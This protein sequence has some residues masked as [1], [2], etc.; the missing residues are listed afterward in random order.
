MTLLRVSTMEENIEEC[1]DNDSWKTVYTAFKKKIVD[2]NHLIEKYSAVTQENTVL[3]K[4]VNDVTT[5]SQSLKLD[6]EK[7]EKDLQNALQDQEPLKQLCASL[8]D[9]LQ[10]HEQQKAALEN[11]LESYKASVR[12]YEDLLKQKQQEVQSVRETLSGKRGKGEAKE[13]VLSLEKKLQKETKELRQLHRRC[14]RAHTLFKVLDEKLNKKGILTPLEKRQFKNVVSILK[15]PP[16]DSDEQPGEDC[17]SSD[18]DTGKIDGNDDADYLEK[19]L[20]N[21]NGNCSSDSEDNFTAVPDCAPPAEKAAGV[22]GEDQA[23]GRSQELPEGSDKSGEAV[24]GKGEENEAQ[25]TDTPVEK[26]EAEATKEEVVNPCPENVVAT[27]SEEQQACAS[28]GSVS[29]SPVK[30]SGGALDCADRGDQPCTIA[31]SVPD[32]SNN[33]QPAQDDRESHQLKT[34]ALDGASANCDVNEEVPMDTADKQPSSSAPLQTEKELA[35]TSTGLTEPLQLGAVAPV[36]SQSD[37]SNAGKRCPKEQQQAQISSLFQQ[38]QILNEGRDIEIV[39]A[40]LKKITSE[41]HLTDFCSIPLSPLPPSPP[42]FD[43]EPNVME[44]E[45]THRSVSGDS[46]SIFGNKY[47]DSLPSGAPPISKSSSSP[48]KTTGLSRKEK[49][50][51]KSKSLPFSNMIDST[52]SDAVFGRRP[53]HHQQSEGFEP[54]I[55]GVELQSDEQPVRIPTPLWSHPVESRKIQTKF[56]HDPVDGTLNVRARLPKDSVTKSHLV[57]TIT[58]ELD[59]VDYDFHLAYKE[60]PIS[61]QEIERARSHQPLYITP[62][63][64]DQEEF[65]LPTGPTRRVPSALQ[66]HSPAQT[67]A[68]NSLPPVRSQPTDVQ[69][70]SILGHKQKPPARIPPVSFVCSRSPRRSEASQDDMAR[71]CPQGAPGPVSGAPFQTRPLSPLPPTPLKQLLLLPDGETPKEQP[72]PTLLP[73]LKRGRQRKLATIGQLPCIPDDDIAEQQNGG[74]E[75][76]R[77]SF[78]FHIDGNSAKFNRTRSEA[79]DSIL[80]SDDERQPESQEQEL[81]VSKKQRISLFSTKVSTEK[82]QKKPLFVRAGHLADDSTAHGHAVF[83]EEDTG[84]AVPSSE[85][86]DTG[87][88]KSSISMSPR[89]ARRTQRNTEDSFDQSEAYVSPDKNV[90]S[91]K[92]TPPAKKRCISHVL[93]ETLKSPDV[94]SPVSGSGSEFPHGAPRSKEAQVQEGKKPARERVPAPPYSIFVTTPKH[95]FLMTRAR[96]NLVCNSTVKGALDKLAWLAITPHVTP[97]AVQSVAHSLRSLSDVIAI[98]ILSYL[99]NTTANPFLGYVRKEVKPPLMTPTEALMLQCLECVEEK[100]KITEGMF[101]LLL[102]AL[103]AR[104]FSSRRPRTLLG[105]TAYCRMIAGVCKRMGD[106]ALLR[107]VLWDILRLFCGNAPFLVAAVVGVWPEVLS[108]YSRD[109]SSDAALLGLRYILF[110]APH[111]LNATLS[112]QTRVIF[113]ELGNLYPLDTHLN[114]TDV[115]EALVSAMDTITSTASE[116]K[117]DE[118]LLHCLTLEEVCRRSGDWQWVVSV[119]LKKLWLLVGKLMKNSDVAAKEYLCTVV[120]LFGGIWRRFPPEENLSSLNPY[121]DKVEMLLQE[122]ETDFAVQEA[123]VK[124]V[125]LLPAVERWESLLSVIRAWQGNHKDE[126]LKLKGVER[127]LAK[128]R[129]ISKKMKKKADKAAARQS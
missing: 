26:G 55:E 21:G 42:L 14:L 38:Q 4:K 114:V 96:G 88:A 73:A 40:E 80:P 67:L 10:S 17:P 108:S 45:D 62:T 52:G 129:N 11:T 41:M 120:T 109:G 33:E 43:I 48:R 82:A 61:H 111:T 119:V 18:E 69:P 49:C 59:P 105:M 57:P 89:K 101:N 30:E 123:F 127:T 77:V 27:V 53:F 112:E 32:S 76:R 93:P 25:T 8:R 68:R 92:V 94:L 65:R 46:S 28:S 87:A 23:G 50:K 103:R 6:C 31:C 125:F 85:H 20:M 64:T 7:Y 128:N 124:S 72:Q 91:D 5:L 118:F 54:H 126:V 99:G 58:V 113:Q 74:I 9:Q 107:V 83:E 116:E 110:H 78:G 12:Q 104:L 122:N 3:C 19:L 98:T 79:N 29:D 16:T 47:R 35:C 24:D 71:D 1:I 39:R 63:D 22:D 90:S 75:K 84:P 34:H 97:E 117:V 86:G 106:I 102:T 15:P 51:N 13:K 56:W 36:K 44:V 121:L 2:T 115:A 66:T 70:K 81:P 95:N 100:R 60:V 37:G